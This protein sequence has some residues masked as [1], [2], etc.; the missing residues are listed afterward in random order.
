MLLI[1][2]RVGEVAYSL[3]LPMSLAGDLDV[4]VVSQIRRDSQIF[5]ASWIVRFSCGV[6]KNDCRVTVEES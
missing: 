4:L 6:R 5:V 2:D 1:L 3:A